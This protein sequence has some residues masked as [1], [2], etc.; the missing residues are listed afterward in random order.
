M[1]SVVQS[2][3][4]WL[5]KEDS[6]CFGDR[7]SR[8]IW[9]TENAPAANYWLFPGGLTAKSLFKEARYC[10][11][12]GQFLATIVLG[13]A[14]IERTLSALFYGAGRN[15]LERASLSKLLEEARENGLIASSEYRELE[16]IRKKRNSYAH[17]RK[18]GHKEGVESNSIAADEAPY[19]I[20]EQDAIEVI[21]SVLNLVSK[22]SV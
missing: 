21:V 15:D 7:L 20:I 5:S 12:Y 13:L 4:K 11:V 19:E 1:T 10:F 6:L 17:F 14:Y 8:L 22:D 2:G 16:R 9:L 18:P 3:S